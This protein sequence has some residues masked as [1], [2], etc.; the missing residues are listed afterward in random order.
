MLVNNVQALLLSDIPDPSDFPTPDLRQLDAS[1]RCTICGELYDAPV[2]LSCGHC[3]CSLCI[4]EHIVKEPE[5]PSC[6]K[7]TNEGQFRINPALEEVIAAWKTVRPNVLQLSKEQVE[8][9]SQPTETPRRPRTPSRKKRKR[10]LTVGSSDDDI[11]CVAGPSSRKID[12][13]RH[14]GSLSPSPKK[15]SGKSAKR[16]DMEPSS[17]PREE[18]LQTEKPVSLVQ[19]PICDRFVEYQSI[20]THMDGPECTSA[21]ST[22]VGKRRSDA[23]GEWSKI[24][25]GNGARKGKNKQ[26]DGSPHDGPRER[27]P[28]ASYDVL[29][30]KAVKD[31]LLSHKL[32]TTGDR[33]TWIARHQRWV[34]IYNANLDKSEV[35][36]KSVQDLR[37]ELRKWE[38]DRRGRKNVIDD[39]VVYAAQHHSEFKRLIEEA[40][41][42]K[43][44][45]AAPT[46]APAAAPSN[47]HDDDDIVFDSEEELN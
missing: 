31:L 15:N 29:K 46:P 3:F 35:N 24:L 11:I 21:T 7:P 33:K 2:T 39:P 38:E 9:I 28:T 17:D 4:R 36:Q 20:N 26:K 34:M 23:K 41:K 27:I 22:P 10:S 14:S 37:A 30:D 32:S 19:C 47:Q 40:R 25:G 6:R 13:S 5:C 16:K 12:V 42:S 8:R 45:K 43:D 1:V 44:A 18:E